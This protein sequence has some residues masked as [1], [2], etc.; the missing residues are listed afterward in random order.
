MNSVDD[1]L[2][3]VK[4]LYSVYKM[5]NSQSRFILNDVN[6]LAIVALILF[7]MTSLFFLIIIFSGLKKT[8]KGKQTRYN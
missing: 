7:S 8:R 3:E 5:N 1:I 6:I 2:I 4:N